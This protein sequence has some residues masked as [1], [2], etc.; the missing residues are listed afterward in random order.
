MHYA[1]ESMT[2]D[3]D[4]FV[5]C[6]V[7]LEGM[8]SKFFTNQIQNLLQD[9]LNQNLLFRKSC[10]LFF[11]GAFQAFDQDRDGTIK[12]SILEVSQ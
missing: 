9:N 6:L 4:S 1:D 5:H 8:F 11:I 3:F 12:L 2:I 7:R 10:S